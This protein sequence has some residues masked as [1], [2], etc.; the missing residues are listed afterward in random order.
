M[1]ENDEIEIRLRIN[2]QRVFFFFKT[3]LISS[4]QKILLMTDSE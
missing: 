4:T 2:Y 1:H 3:S